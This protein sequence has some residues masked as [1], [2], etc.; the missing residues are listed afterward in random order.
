MALDEVTSRLFVV[1]RRPAVLGVFSTRD[2]AMSNRVAAC[3]DADDVFV[4]T[5][6]QRLYVIC[7]EGRVETFDATPGRLARI[8]SM[9]TVP[10]SRTGL[11]SAELDRLFVAVRASDGQ[12]AAVWVVKPD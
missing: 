7:G 12:P 11:F 9:T 3:G 1:F 8:G 10:G 6:R 5:R 4:D 2:G